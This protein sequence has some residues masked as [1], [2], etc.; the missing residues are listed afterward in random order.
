MGNEKSDIPVLDTITCN[1]IEG[2]CGVELTPE[3]FDKMDSLWKD[4]PTLTKH[5][6]LTEKND[7]KPIWL[8]YYKFEMIFNSMHYNNLQ[9]QDEELHAKTKDENF[10]IKALSL[11]MGEEYVDKINKEID[12]FSEKKHL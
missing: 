6:L 12:D 1:T 4:F 9:E 10:R 3:A 5:R 11:L 7:W 8:T 2:Y